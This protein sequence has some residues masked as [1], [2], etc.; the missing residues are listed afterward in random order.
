MTTEAS[1]RYVADIFVSFPAV[2][3]RRSGGRSGPYDVGLKRTTP[4]RIGLV[5]I[6]DL[7]VVT[8]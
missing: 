7:P 8:G 5:Q 3:P 6:Y 4:F 2:T 1:A